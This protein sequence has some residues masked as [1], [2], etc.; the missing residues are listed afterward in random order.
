MKSPLPF[1][2]ILT[3]AFGAL[4]ACDEPTG[5]AAGPT[6]EAQFRVYPVHV[7]AVCTSG[8]TLLWNEATKEWTCGSCP[9][10]SQKLD[11]LA[12]MPLFGPNQWQVVAANPTQV[13]REV[14]IWALCGREIDDE[15]LTYF[16]Q[17]GYT[18]P[19]DGQPR[20]YVASC[21]FGGNAPPGRLTGG[22]FS[23]L[24]DYVPGEF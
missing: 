14:Q 5:P 8:Q 9:K 19:P 13:E 16:V 22:G 7:E 3:V 2:A 21:E 18:V 12:S 10:P 11:I 15:W 1:L 23:I 6:G 24:K 17:R 4:S 20:P